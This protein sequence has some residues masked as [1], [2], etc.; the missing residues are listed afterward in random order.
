MPSQGMSYGM[1]V[2]VQLDKQAE[3]D[4]LWSWVKAFMRNPSGQFQGAS[5]SGDIMVW[6]IRGQLKRL[7]V[8]VLQAS[9]R[10]SARSR[11][12]PWSRRRRPTGRS[13]SPP[14]SCSHTSDGEASRAGCATWDC[15]NR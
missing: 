10:G 2:A 15:V 9:L 3:Y 8:V 6:V 11:A 14:P 1:M 5:L 13:G 4:R 7:A 12:R